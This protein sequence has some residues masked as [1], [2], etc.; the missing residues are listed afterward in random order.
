MRARNAIGDRIVGHGI[1]VSFQFGDRVDHSNHPVVAVIQAIVGQLELPIAT[2][3]G[4][5]EEEGLRSRTWSRTTGAGG[6]NLRELS[7]V[8]QRK[9]LVHEGEVDRRVADLLR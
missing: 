9:K 2:S 3:A 7:D 8:N 4:H 1:A 6:A 5:A